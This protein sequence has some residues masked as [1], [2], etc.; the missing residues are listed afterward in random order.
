V[1][2]RQEHDLGQSYLLEDYAFLKAVSDDR[3]SWLDFD[4]AV[5]AH[6][7]VDA[8][9]ESARTGQPVEL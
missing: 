2:K 7:V 3:Q 6:A 1:Y 8:I 9:Y 5:R 4:V